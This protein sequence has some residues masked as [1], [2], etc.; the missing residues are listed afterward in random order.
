MQVQA[1]MDALEQFK[2]EQV[3]IIQIVLKKPSRSRSRMARFGQ[4]LKK[5]LPYFHWENMGRQ[6]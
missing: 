3:Q 1:Q 4:F 6:K 2:Q 5:M